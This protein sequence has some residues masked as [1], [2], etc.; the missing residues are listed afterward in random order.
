[1]RKKT[2]PHTPPPPPTS[3]FFFTILFY[4]FCA[5]SFGATGLIKMDA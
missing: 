1:M 4:L 3:P 5:I 2:H